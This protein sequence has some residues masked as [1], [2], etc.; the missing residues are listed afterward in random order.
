MTYLVLPVEEKALYR[1][2]A[3]RP[4]RA[5]RPA[6][7]APTR[8]AAPLKA[9]GAGAM[10][11]EGTP[12]P[13]GAAATVEL[14]ADGGGTTTTA[15]LTGATEGTLTTAG[16]EVTAGTTVL[17]GG[18][19]T[20][21]L[22][23]ATVSTGVETAATAGVDTTTAFEVG[24]AGLVRVHGQLVMVMVVA[25]ETLIS[26]SSTAVH[27]S[28]LSDSVHHTGVGQVSGIWAVGG[29]RI[30]DLSGVRNVPCGSTGREGESRDS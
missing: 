3:A 28:Y 16:T 15:V 25:F 9:S 10:G 19:T 18:T 11:L 1:R 8:V 13:D 23:T 6:D 30:D 20:A 12:V 4:R 2:K 14:T 27:R 29:V 17:G 7:E 26:S 24:I 21:G 5:T 22:E